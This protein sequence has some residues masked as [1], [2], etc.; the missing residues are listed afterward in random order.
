MPKRGKKIAQEQAAQNRPPGPMH[1]GILAYCNAVSVKPCKLDPQV[2]HP[3][4]VA[5][6]PIDGH[7][8]IVIYGVHPNGPPFR[9]N[10]PGC[11]ETSCRF[12]IPE[13]IV[14]QLRENEQSIVEGIEAAAG[15]SGK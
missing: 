10:C 1:I 6:R 8:P 15:A 9:Y 14:K 2:Q 13:E 12:R 3:R 4:V 11:D 5:I 7:R